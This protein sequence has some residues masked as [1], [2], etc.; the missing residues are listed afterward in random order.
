MK[1][2]FFLP[3]LAAMMFS[4]CSSDE[5]TVDNPAD[6]DGDRYMSVKIR[7][8]GLN[9]SRAD[10]VVGNPEFENGTSQESSINAS[11]LWFFFFDE[12]GNA[13]PLAPAD[14]SGTVATNMVTPTDITVEIGEGNVSEI[15]GT[16]VLGTGTGSYKGQTPSQVLV[17]ANGNK[18]RLGELSNL[19]MP[20]L[21]AK[22]SAAPTSWAATAKFLMSSSIY[23]DKD[24]NKVTAVDIREK[25]K[26]T[27]EEAEKDA[28]VLHIERVAAK[29]RATYNESYQ[30]G[31]RDG[32]NN[33]V[34]DGE[35]NFYDINGDGDGL[36]NE[37]AHFTAVIN[38]WQLLNK[39]GQSAAFK[40]L[41]TYTET[42]TLLGEN[43]AT[44]WVWN[45]Y[46]RFRSYWSN[47]NQGTVWQQH[48][49]TYDLYSATASKNGSYTSTGT[50]ASFAETNTEYCYENTGYTNVAETQRG[51]NATAIA[52]KATIMKRGTTT[53]IDM[54]RFAGSYYTRAAIEHLIKTSYI[55]SHPTAKKE[56]L[57]V[58]FND[59]AADDNTYTAT[60]TTNDGASTVMNTYN[61]ILWWKNGVTSYL[62]NIKHLNNKPGVV[63]NHIYDYHFDAL[64]GLGV[65]GSEPETPELTDSYLAARVYVLNWHVV[66]NTVTLE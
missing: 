6:Q 37:K 23:F 32:N 14:V 55:A 46:T 42:V 10:A 8:A 44:N 66:S 7:T 38:G 62:L 3:A 58:T 5:P 45:D 33:V 27:K 35:F 64:I 59:N 20:A 30:V 40:Q 53:G 51:T 63:R 28:A 22:T 17:V 4:S 56:D 39:A 11:D 52:V 24:G 48:Y 34:N 47:S 65:P 50:G 15:T 19:N 57:T 21:L 31:S 61:S 29:V 41:G 36:V 54:Y 12:N 25:I 26:K 60:V 18:D 43:N 9:G 2:L 13:F 49:N 1:K 16:L